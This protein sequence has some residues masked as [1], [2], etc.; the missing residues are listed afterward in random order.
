MRETRG[1]LDEP[2]ADSWDD[3]DRNA[4]PP[5]IPQ[6]RNGIR[7]ER[8][9]SGGYVVMHESRGRSSASNVSRGG[10]CGGGGGGGC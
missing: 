7:V 10:S 3:L 8:R 9:A 1:D 5:P 2:S 6:S 4:K